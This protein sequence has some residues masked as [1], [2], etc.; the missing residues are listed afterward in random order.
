MKKQKSAHSLARRMVIS[1]VL[2]IIVGFFFM[3]LR[4]TLN[5]SG[6]GNIWNTINTLLFQ[7][8]SAEGASSAVGLFYII[9]QMF[10]RALQLV[11]IPMVFTSIALAIGTISDTR[12]L[13]RISF[14]TV[15]WFLLCYFFALLL[16]GIVGMFLYSNGLFDANITGLSASE[17]S[18]GSNPLLVILNAVPSNITAV[19]GDNTAVLAVVFL[20]VVVGLCM[21]VLGE[22]K[23]HTLK[24][25]FQEINDVVVVFLNFVVTKVGPV[26]IFVL[27]SRTFATYGIDYLRP[28]LVYVITTILLLL[29]YLFI[30]YALIIRFGTKLNPVPFIKKISKVAMFGFSTSSSAAALPLNLETTSQELGVDEKVASFVLPLGMTINMNGTAIMQVIA[31]L[32][33][34]G[35]SGQQVTIPMLIMIAVMVALCSAGTPAAP[36]AGAVI[37][38]TILSG[39]G[40]TTDSALLAYSLIL[41]IN[42]PIEMLCTSLNVVGDSCTC[43]YVAKSENM[44][45]ETVYNSPVK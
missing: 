40:F 9:G 10:I 18:T 13:G 33:I 8:I 32:F 12:T 3:W 23:T 4:E 38:F 21:N 17:G 5:A 45:N 20:A 30:G 36:G 26:A 22:E 41:A 24:K 31:T 15:A 29:I 44:L 25:L 42:R 35:C 11:I 34:A 19:F 28:A 6:N 27:L 16:A 7:D 14:K 43:I 37:L 39:F 1:L 2:G